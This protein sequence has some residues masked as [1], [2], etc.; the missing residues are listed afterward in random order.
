MPE[1]EGGMA[2]IVF[3]LKAVG[4]FPYS[5]KQSLASLTPIYHLHQLLEPQ[6]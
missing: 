1:M 3:L 5:W 4:A 2:P 6:K